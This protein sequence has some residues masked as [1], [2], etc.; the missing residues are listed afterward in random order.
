M[1]GAVIGRLAADPG[2]AAVEEIGG[3]AVRSRSADLTRN[4]PSASGALVEKRSSCGR[5]RKYRWPRPCRPDS[6]CGVRL[7]RNVREGEPRACPAW[8]VSTLPPL[9]LTDRAT[10][11][12]GQ[13]EARR[14]GAHVA[15]IAGAV[16]LEHRD[17]ETGS[18]R[19]RS[20]APR[21]PAE[22]RADIERTPRASGPRGTAGRDGPPGSAT[23]M[24][25][26]LSSGEGR[27]TR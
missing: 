21:R 7:A 16:L 17:A 24:S 27:S 9:T 25:S 11:P 1:Y 26:N 22:K 8:R 15:P 14:R 19:W 5:P 18:T 23:L 13:G 3:V 10:R 4:S 6:D 20:C 2:H 12:W